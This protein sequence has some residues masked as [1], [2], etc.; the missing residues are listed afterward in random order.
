[1]HSTTK[2]FS[3]TSNGSKASLKLIFENAINISSIHVLLMFG[4]YVIKINNQC[5]QLL[6]LT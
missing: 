2:I 4:T 5:I 1:M 6:H 3:L